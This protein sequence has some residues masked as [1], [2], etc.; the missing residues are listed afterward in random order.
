[1]LRAIDTKSLRVTVSTAV[2]TQRS[3]L[4]VAVLLALFC[5]CAGVQ[6][7]SAHA[8]RWAARSAVDVFCILLVAERLF[9]IQAYRKTSKQDAFE[10]QRR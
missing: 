3:V 10:H 1:M 4:G 5:C 6:A 2:G 9:I 7:K 8:I